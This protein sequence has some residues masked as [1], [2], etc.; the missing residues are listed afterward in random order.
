MGLA[1][2]FPGGAWADGASC[3]GTTRT[4]TVPGRPRL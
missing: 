4:R 2:G 3:A 1:A